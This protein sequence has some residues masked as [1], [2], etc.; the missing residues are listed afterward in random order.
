[1]CAWRLYRCYYISSISRRSSGRQRAWYCRRGLLSAILAG[2][3]TYFLK[4]PGLLKE[5][6]GST[7]DATKNATQNTHDVK[8]YGYLCPK[9]STAPLDWKPCVGAGNILAPP[10][11]LRSALPRQLLHSLLHP[12]LFLLLVVIHIRSDN[13]IERP[14]N[15][16][17]CKLTRTVLHP[18]FSPQYHSIKPNKYSTIAKPH[19]INE[20]SAIAK[21]SCV[22]DFWP[23]NSNKNMVAFMIT[24]TETQAEVQST[25]LSERADK[26]RLRRL[27]LVTRHHYQR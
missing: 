22:A 15:E 13:H 6:G 11:Y 26:A 24:I 19:N 14:K 8:N 9:S 12:V 21:Y 2:L 20:I 4:S 1:M 18:L 10:N 7:S 5:S 25:I 17:N 23:L 27:K 3:Q 16:A